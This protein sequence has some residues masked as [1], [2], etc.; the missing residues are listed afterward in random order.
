MDP[1]IVVT[2]G[3]GRRRGAPEILTPIPDEDDLCLYPLENADQTLLNQVTRHYHRTLQRTLPG[4]QFLKRLGLNDPELPE[5]FKLGYA[6]RTLCHRLGDA[7]RMDGGAVRGRLQRLGVLRPSGHE[8]FRGAL[9]VPVLDE[10][11]NTVDMWGHKTS[12]DQRSQ[13]PLQTSLF[14]P[15]RGIFNVKGIRGQEEIILCGGLPDAMTFWC[16]GFKNVTATLGVKGLTAEHLEAFQRTGTKRVVIAFERT[17]LGDDEARLVAQALDAVHIDCR[18]LDLPSSLD[19][20]SYTRLRYQ[21]KGSL[22]DMLKG[23]HPFRQMYI[24]LRE[25]MECPRATKSSH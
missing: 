16:Q 17:Q 3:H 1:R 21:T 18:R 22:S 5:T 6:D 14:D 2:P 8:L 19:V 4:Q 25:T 24:S 12:F 20:N 13:T 9:V 23:A 11:G 7:R 15:P 10:R